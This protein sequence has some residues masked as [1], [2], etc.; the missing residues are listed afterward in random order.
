MS[1]V[2]MVDKYFDSTLARLTEAKRFFHFVDAVYSMTNLF[3]NEEEY[4][5]AEATKFFFAMKSK[6]QMSRPLS[7]A[8]L[9]NSEEKQEKDNLESQNVSWGKD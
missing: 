5:V 9:R 3:P 1:W 8:N 6:R 7:K 4:C 2:D